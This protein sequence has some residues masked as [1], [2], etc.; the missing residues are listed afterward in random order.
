MATTHQFWVYIMTNKGNNVFYV[1][2]TNDLKRRVFEHKNKINPGF[3]AMYKCN[4][5]IYFEE[6]NQAEQ[7]I[8]R[9]KLLK[10]WK[11]EWKKELISGMN[12]EWN[13]LSE[14]WFCESSCD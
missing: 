4:K 8:Q 11:R 14:G 3:T 12:P 1:G 2:F 6:H 7:G 10:K 13:D 9:E 5:L